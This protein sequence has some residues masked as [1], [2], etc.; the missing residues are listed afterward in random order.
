[1]GEGLFSRFFGSGDYTVS[2]TIDDINGNSLLGKSVTQPKFYSDRGEFLI[3][4]T[5]YCG[6]VVT[7]S[8]PGA[9][10]SASYAVN[11]QNEALFPWLANYASNFEYFKF[12]GL[13][14][15]FQSTSGE[16]VASTN[17]AI[18]TIMALHN[19]D[20]TDPQPQDKLSFLQYGNA[21]ACR[22]SENW[23]LGAECEPDMAVASKFYVDNAATGNDV[24]LTTQGQLIVA[25]QGAQ[26]ASVTVGE[27]YVTYRIRFYIAKKGPPNQRGWLVIRNSPA[28]TLPF[29]AAAA[30]LLRSSGNLAVTQQPTANGIT[31]PGVPGASYR[32]TIQTSNVSGV[33][34]TAMGA[35]T[36][37]NCSVFAGA[38]A[39]NFSSGAAFQSGWAQYFLYVRCPTTLQGGAA[40]TVTWA[41][42]TGNYTD[43]SAHDIIVE[44][45]SRGEC[46]V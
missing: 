20:I 35:A 26:A 3:E 39:G 8:T 25:T 17:T 43:L 18:G 31:F 36:L 42:S 15:K 45:L 27:L 19:P 13:V 41:A 29:S 11:P 40:V 38:A 4:H 10:Q 21:V 28:T 7:S 2:N 12:E 1:M 32:I 23:L 30:T 24:R 16:A 33:N 37:T 5:E 44:E 9:Y 22:T 6:D 14:F 46:P 34:A